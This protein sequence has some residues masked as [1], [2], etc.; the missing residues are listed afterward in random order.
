MT[1]AHILQGL[2]ASGKSTFARTLPGERF[3]MD[4]YRAMMGLTHDNWSKEREAIVFDAFLAGVRSAIANGR[5]VILDNTHLNPGWPKRYRKEFA[6]EGVT[7]KVHSFMDVAL[8][9][10]IAR[11]AARA[12]KPGE[13]SVGKDVILKLHASFTKASASGWRLT[14]KWMNPEPYVKP[15]PV[16]WAPEL[17]TVVICDIDGTVADHEG[18]RSPYDYTKVSDDKPRKNVIEIIQA[19]E[20]IGYMVVFVSGRDDSCRNETLSWLDE[21]IWVGRVHKLYMREAGDKRPDYIV[22]HKIFEREIRGKY[23][24][25]AVFD[26]R[27]QVVDLWR[28]LGLDCMQVNYGDF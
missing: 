14:D 19:L 22:K 20:S 9:E 1:T 10:C 3:N 6:R 16:E 26:D 13:V 5:D 7:F 8:E 11:D 21:N 2:P 17:P 23:N 15:V 18:V 24:V 27:Q 4:D 25:L 28:D 12:D